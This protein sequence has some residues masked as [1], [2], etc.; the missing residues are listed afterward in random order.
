[1]VTIQYMSGMPEAV[2]CTLRSH[3]RATTVSLYKTTLGP[4]K[5]QKIC[6]GVSRSSLLYPLQRLTHRIYMR[7]W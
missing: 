2:D 3:G 1:M 5:E 7:D 6:P 4:L